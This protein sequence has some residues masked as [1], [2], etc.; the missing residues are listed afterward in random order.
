MKKEELYRR[1][2]KEILIFDGAMGT[3]LQQSGLKAGECPE[4]M[5]L[6]HEESIFQIHRKYVEAGCRIIQTNTFGAN[7][8]KLDLYGL[9]DQVEA[10]NAKGAAIARKAA[11]EGCLVAGDMGPIG[12]LL[13]PLGPLSYEEAYHTF[14]EQAKALIEGGVD[15]INI[16]TMSDIQEA[17]IAVI[18]AKDAGD[19]PV[20]CTMTFQKDLRTL[21][22]TDPE[23]AAAILEALDVAVL[24]A[25]C[26]FGPDMM[27][28]VLERMYKITKKP[29]I[30]QP[31]AGLPKLV[32]GETCF[33]LSPEEMAGYAKTL[34]AAGANII[35]GCCGTT[36]GHMEAMAKT[37]SGEKPIQRQT[38]TCSKLSSGSKTVF[39][40]EALPYNII[41]ECINLT[42]RKHL[43]ESV[44]ENNFH[45]IAK[46]AQSQVTAG[47][48][49]IDVNMGIRDGMVREETAMVNG[50]MAVQRAV[51]APLSIDT[52][53][54]EVMEAALKVYRGKP[55]LNS[56][57]GEDASLDRVIHLAK[58]YGAAILGLTLDQQG[59]PETV[60]KRFHLAK[61][62]VN[63]A[64]KAG[65]PKEDIFIDTLT[66]TA[67]AQQKWVPDTLKTLRR[68][69]EELG[70]RT[71]LGVSNISHGLPNRRDL[72]AAYLAMALEAGLDVPIINPYEEKIWAV[73]RSA[74]V[75]TG[76]DEKAQEYIRWASEKVEAERSKEQKVKK[77]S[78]FEAVIEGE[79][80]RVPNLIKG[81]QQQGFS[82]MEIIQEQVVKA[83]EAV[84][85]GYEKQTYFLPQLLMAAEA[86]QSAFVCLK[87]DLE[88]ESYE[89]IGTYL[90]ATVKGDIHDIGKNIVS[91]MLQNHG[92]KVVDLGKDVPTETIIQKAIEEKPDIIGLSALM[93]TTMQEMQEVV[94]GL[95]NKDLN[96]PVMVGGAV[97]T[98]VFAASIGAEYAADAVEAVK[99]AKRIIEKKKALE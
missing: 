23:T 56:T 53:N 25:N 42:G 93:T 18:A 63:R 30:V 22:G 3:M 71:I 45:V 27:I 64:V 12:K 52:V 16:E 44:R 96:I 88:Q 61:K 20:I 1:L 55:L 35:G 67:G 62:I 57:N 95:K 26:S 4:A 31:N 82:A 46:E 81:L 21:T 76:R 72:T 37:L 15:L 49:I 36:P 89:K 94:E 70:V 19:V 14:Y 40:D 6:H 78:L 43:M 65:I 86:A 39:I 99:A 38:I 59:I 32:N 80:E 60:E 41:G 58:R 79:R 34:V 13:S 33:D 47:A 28:N 2:E 97:V 74:N 75:L 87:E 7:R 85:E 5:N 69:K 9:A 66:L 8:I 77:E 50:I 73:L 48:Q 68:V 11:G 90:I 91:I 84:G 29:L 51:D 54:V 24:G 92:F 10:I 83:L 98:E 17:K